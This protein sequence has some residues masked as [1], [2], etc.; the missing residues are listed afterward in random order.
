MN[1]VLFF[2]TYRSLGAKVYRLKFFFIRLTD[3]D[4]FL[5][6]VVSSGLWAFIDRTGIA[7]KEIFLGITYDPWLWSGGGLA[8][9]LIL[10][11][12]NK[13][14]PDDS[15]EIV[16]RGLFAPKLYAPRNKVGDRFWRASDERIANKSLK[17]Q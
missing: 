4:I 14:R 5:M 13:V 16:L 1:N 17:K 9:A 11:L 12:L 15:I 6:F 3:V 8:T 7:Y 10:S 2:K